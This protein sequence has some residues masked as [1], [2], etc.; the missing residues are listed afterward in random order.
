MN[1]KIIV[2]LGVMIILIIGGISLLFGYVGFQNECNRYENGIVAQYDVNK[3][4][5]DNGYKSVLEIASVPENYVDNLKTLFQ[6]AITG[7]YGEGGSKAV[8]QLIQ[9][10]N[11]QLPSDMYVKIQQTIEIFRNRFT[12]S[13][14]ELVA[15]KQEYKNFYTATISGR[16]F[17][18]IGNYPRIEF[19]K[20]D[21]VTSDRTEGAFQT[22]RDEP[23][24]LHKAN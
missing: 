24:L 13:Q 17:N 11:P 18:I 1:K 23:L 15:K 10:Q 19:S 16:V 3:N 8:I 9:E 22:K 7:R 2:F 5:Y 20:Y 4:I 6:A 12:Q 14:T 21:I